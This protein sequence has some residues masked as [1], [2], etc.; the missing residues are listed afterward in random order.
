MTPSLS[1]P[2]AK[3]ERTKTQIKDLDQKIRTFLRGSAHEVVSEFDVDADADV[4][5]FRPKREVPELFAVMA[6]EVLHNLRS[7][8]D[9]LACQIA[10]KNSGSFKETYFP[11]GAR[12]D[13]FEAELAR[14]GKKLSS[15]AIDM[16][17]ALKPYKGGNNLL[18]ALHDANRRD[19]HVALS[20]IN[21]LST[22][23]AAS[24]L[25]VLSGL[26][27]VIGSR[28]GQHLLLDKPRPTAEEIAVMPSPTGIYTVGPSAKIL[29][30]TEGC[31]PDQSREFLT[32]TPGAKF[33]T[34]MR[35]TFNIALSDV[36]G[37]ELEPVVA[38]LNQ[39]RDLVESILLTFK[40]RF[41]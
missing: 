32:T 27:L 35:P 41:F 23:N 34:N 5:S 15:D 37:F 13:I 28:Y 1:L 25:T 36:E 22:S 10:L 40:R 21:L 29:F 2:I 33:Q 6:G 11:F 19:K 9:N 4:W 24:Y 26:A 16:V 20:P 17:R 7:A 12:A 3:V 30:G 8:L 38:T 39:M 18:W 31:T 14:K